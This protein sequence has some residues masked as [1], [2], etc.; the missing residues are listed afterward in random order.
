MA[1]DRQHSKPGQRPHGGKRKKNIVLPLIVFIIAALLLCIV[2]FIIIKGYPQKISAYRQEAYQLVQDSS[3]DTF[4]PSQTGAIYDKNGKVITKISSSK[5]SSYVSYDDIP[6]TFVQAMVSTEDKKFYQHHGIDYMAILRAAI[7]YVTNNGKIT[8]GGSTITMQLA[9]TIFLSTEQTLSRKIEEAFI[10]KYLE[11]KYSKDE[12]MEFYLNNIYF[13]NGYYGIKAAAKGYFSADLDELD[14]SQV[15]FLCAIPNSPTY[16]DPLT[17]MDHTIERRNLILKN[18]LNEGY[19]TQDEYLEAATEDIELNQS[20]ESTA[21]ET[22]NYI[23]TYAYHCATLALMEQEGFDFQYDFDSDSEREKY[24]ENYNTVYSECQTKI[25][26]GKYNLYTSID[27]DIQDK[28]QEAVDDQLDGFYTTTDDGDYKVQGAGVC[29]D[30]ETGYVVAVVGGRSNSNLSG[31]TLNRSY[32]SYR[33][34]GSSIKPLNVYT[35]IFENTD[36][37]PS[38]YVTDQKIEDGP[39]NAD[40]NYYGRVTIREAIERSLNTVAWQLYEELTPKVGLSYLKK[41]HFSQIVDADETLATSIGGFTNGVTPVEMAAG[42]CTLANDG[43]YREPT[44][45]VRIV[46][47][48]GNT[49]YQSD[50]TETRVYTE[51]AARTMTDC[52]E[53]VIDKYAGTGYGLGLSNG[54]P[55]AGKTGTTDDSKDGWFVGYT[56]YYTTS[57]WVGCDTPEEIEDLH[58]ATYPGEI[59]QQFMDDIHQDLDYEN[60]DDLSNYDSYSDSSSSSS[61]SSYSYYGNNDSGYGS[62]SDD[63]YSGYGSSS[64]D[65]SSKY[66]SSSEDIYNG[67][68]SSS[69]DSY[70][71]SS[72]GGGFRGGRQ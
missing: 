42:Y 68:D 54:M 45:I 52:L 47:Y 21:T 67:Y 4:V 64:E 8:Q 43:L 33:Q 57:V 27:T 38:S 35:P 70:Y 5:I 65:S 18:M 34:P 48:S 60:L 10:A 46:D 16:Y 36:Y 72:S 40:G 15:A 20:T 23:D 71:G 37:T 25:Y 22:H 49:I 44:C 50:R 2:A 63:T 51:E 9:R 1:S 55:A 41:M 17:N 11:E 3:K 7:S 53:D 28:L 66:G 61:D 26:S 24:E 29:I 59:W 39:E 69:D 14:L 31:Y 30:N 58:G 32:Q 56:H 13:A 6:E 19:I 12:I 62:S